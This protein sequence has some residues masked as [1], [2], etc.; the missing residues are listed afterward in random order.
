[1]RHLNGLDWTALVLLIIGGLNWGLIGF[2]GFNLVAAIFG[3][4]T[5]VSRII[6]AVV[7]LSALYVAVV[8]P[9]FAHRGQEYPR[10]ASGQTA[11]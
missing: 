8:S 5:F 10:G 3:E 4:M 7:G 11:H 6:Y 2:F 9:S 1:M